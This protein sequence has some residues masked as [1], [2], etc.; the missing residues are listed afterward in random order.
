MRSFQIK[1]DVHISG[2]LIKG[3]HCICFKNATE[4]VERQ[5]VSTHTRLNAAILS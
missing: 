3:F 1:E 5:T 4:S 2:V